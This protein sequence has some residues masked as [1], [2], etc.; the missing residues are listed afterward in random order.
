MTLFTLVL[1]GL[2]LPKITM[3]VGFM[4]AGARAIYAIMYLKG[5]SDARKLGTIF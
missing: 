2:F 1:G 5:G 4:I 3:Y